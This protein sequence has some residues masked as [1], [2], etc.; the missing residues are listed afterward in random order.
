MSIADKLQY[1]LDGI[2][3]A[4]DACEEM[5]VIIPDPKDIAELG[6]SIRSI[7]QGNG[8][9]SYPLDWISEPEMPLNQGANVVYKIYPDQQNVAFYVN[10][11]ASYRFSIDWGDGIIESNLPPSS[12]NQ[13]TYNFSTLVAPI[14]N[15]G[16][17]TVVIKIS[18][19]NYAQPINYIRFSQ[20]NGI[21]YNNL[22]FAKVNCENMS[23]AGQM[24]GSGSVTSVY[25]NPSL[26]EAVYVKNLPNTSTF[27]MPQF[28]NNCLRLRKIDTNGEIISS[29]NLGSLLIGTTSLDADLIIENTTTSN[30]TY[31]ALGTVTSAFDSLVYRCPTTGIDYPSSYILSGNFYCQILDIRNFMPNLTASQFNFV[32]ENGYTLLQTV[33]LNWNSFKTA[34]NQI[35]SFS[36]AR[37]FKFLET[38]GTMGNNV[39]TITV[40][41]TNAGIEFLN[42]I[43]PDLYDRT[44]ISAGTLNISF[45][46][47]SND[48]TQ[49]EI[50]A[51]QAKNWTIIS[52]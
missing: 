52:S 44:G 20:V 49:T 17:K 16:N 6:N 4:W 35:I 36:N 29:N 21:P 3:D 26:L 45:T 28:L 39:T 46:P 19:V 34:P 51:I 43:I 8:S 32:N 38:T 5:D 1:T 23:T 25:R 22:L 50:D 2:S 41:G 31:S 27:T 15:D 40:S 13:H 7:E 10:I 30:F 11:Q 33:K 24:F 47:A 48:I 18:P 14:A 42:N 37:L 9:W 12:I